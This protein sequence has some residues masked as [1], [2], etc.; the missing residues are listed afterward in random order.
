MCVCVCVCVCDCVCVCVCVSGVDIDVVITNTPASYC[1]A[2]VFIVCWSPFFMYNL[3][4]LFG[5][6]P[7]N[8]PLSTLIQSAAPLNSAA[9]PIIYG[10]F[11]TRICRNLRYVYTEA[12]AGL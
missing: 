3:L 9:N 12:L 11:S 5:A 2:A 8:D 7:Q 4:E 10:I 6:I 1:F